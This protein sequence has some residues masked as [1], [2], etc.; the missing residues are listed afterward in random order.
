MVLFGSTKSCSI[1]CLA[2]A[3]SS[4]DVCRL[5]MM[6]P[7]SLMVSPPNKLPTNLVTPLPSPCFFQPFLVL[8]L[9]D[10][11]RLILYSFL[12]SFCFL[13]LKKKSYSWIYFSIYKYIYHHFLLLLTKLLETCEL[14]KFEV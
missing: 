8:F 4:S 3:F 2:S 7:T 10:L 6:F 13:N 1:F 9:Y 11:S 12:N 5:S 14:N